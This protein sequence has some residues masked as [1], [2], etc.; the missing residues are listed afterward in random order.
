MRLSLLPLVFRH[1]SQ[2]IPDGVDGLI[3]V[4]ALRFS[5]SVGS[6]FP[7]PLYECFFPGLLLGSRS[8]FFFLSPFLFAAKIHLNV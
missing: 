6:L 5:L 4:A 2:F 7:S 3:G 1:Q 8:R